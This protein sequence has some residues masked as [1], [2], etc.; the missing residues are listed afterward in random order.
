VYQLILMWHV[1]VEVRIKFSTWEC[2]LPYFVEFFLIVCICQVTVDK[3]EHVTVC[4]ESSSPP[5]PLVIA[6][7]NM[8]TVLHPTNGQNEVVMISCLVHNGFHVD[9]APPQPPF[10]QH[11]CGQY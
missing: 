2:L 4:T 8:R 10:Q 9:R 11:F 5:P 3:P 6:T 1:F 7:L